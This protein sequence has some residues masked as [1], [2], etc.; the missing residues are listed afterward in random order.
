MTEV[1]RPLFLAGHDRHSAETAEVRNPYDGTLVARVSVAGSTEYEEAAQACVAAAPV[2]AALPVHERARILRKVSQAL[3][4]RRDEFA[5]RIV[6]E[7]GKPLRDART[8][9]DRAAMTFEVAAEEARRL[10]GGGEVL[11]MDLAPHGEGRV[12]LTRRVPIG[13]IAA[14]SPFNFPLN[15]VAHKLAP[16]LAAGN[17]L[18]L[19]PATRTPLSALALAALMRDAGLPEGALSVLPMSRET[20]DLLVRDDRFRLLTFTG[21]A[22]VGWAMKAKAGRKKVVLELGGNAAV[23]VDEGADVAVA[24][25]RTA[26]GG[27]S[28]AGQSCIS[29]QRVYVH[30][31]QWDA[32]RDAFLERV[33]ELAT[34]DPADE[35]TAVG[36]LITEGDVER[37]ETWTAEAVAAG[38]TVLRGGTRTSNRVFPP[39]VLTNVPAD[40]KICAEEA[41]AP[42]VILERV[43]SLDA[44]IEAV[45]ASA[46]G[47]QAGVFTPSLEG[48]LRAFDRLEVGG[49]LVNDVPTYR[50]D[51]MPYGGVKDSGLGREGPRYAIED[52]SEI[53]LLIVRR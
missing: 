3:A 16:A 14:I 8:E 47:L 43:A 33:D 6:A 1:V 11:P 34:G 49:V 12:A 51:H 35:R 36:P 13:P 23:I 26:T 38:A 46:F 39:T 45:N 21:S 17:P 7:A 9:V 20:G 52:M 40:A 31:R 18:V 37:I 2:V 44:A 25:E 15:L 41:F 53:R 24:A 48:A 32:F 29:V 4:E 5:R 42:I 27:F 10:A 30:D 28:Y 22:E 19:K 50:I